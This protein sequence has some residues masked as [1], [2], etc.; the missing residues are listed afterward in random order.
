MFN[1]V[2]LLHG[3]NEPEEGFIW[4]QYQFAYT[5]DNDICAAVL[6]CKYY[7]TNGQLTIWSGELIAHRYDLLDGD[8]YILI[9]TAGPDKK[10][11][12]EVNPRVQYPSDIRE[13]GIMITNIYCFRSEQELLVWRRKQKII[14]KEGTITPQT[15]W[16]SID[17]EEILEEYY[18]YITKSF[19]SE[20]WAKMQFKSVDE[21]VFKMSC[22]LY[23]PIRFRD[24]V[25]RFRIRINE[26]IL[27]TEF[28]SEIENFDIRGIPAGHL[29]LQTLL[30]LKR[31]ELPAP[32]L[33][34][35]VYDII[36][37]KP[38]FEWQSFHWRG[39]GQFPIPPPANI[40]R[41]VGEVSPVM[42]C[43]TGATWFTKLAWLTKKY[44]DRD[45]FDIEKV[46]DWGCGCG[47]ILRFFLEDWNILQHPRIIGIDIDPVNIAWCK[48]N[49]PNAEFLCIDP[50]PPTTL[51]DNEFDLIYGSSVFTHLTEEDQDKWLLEL[52]RL[53]KPGGF[54]FVTINA[55]LAWFA[56][57]SMR[58]GPRQF[59][60]HISKGIRDSGHVDI[61]VDQKRPGY[62][63]NTTHTSDYVLTHWATIFKIV[64]IIHGFADCQS[65]V[66][67]KK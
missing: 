58:K 21:N 39:F 23:P 6:A 17:C 11:I 66:V 61:G 47:R 29:K 4:S 41:T 60:E 15:P 8:N 19:I 49:L 50:D 55:E 34:L 2:R 24:A 59:F 56:L 9:R 16:K 13:L 65:L 43:F 25:S 33:D 62:Y 54:C 52:R 42:Y 67:L 10:V 7:R 63:R 1:K 12:C 32:H 46:L 26:R 18:H 51:P 48:E 3:F 64:D 57:F 38:T 37:Q 35:E 45:L 30:D 53:L 5:F 40:R 31:L 14:P 36:N 44:I 22:A 27:D 28:K 20:G